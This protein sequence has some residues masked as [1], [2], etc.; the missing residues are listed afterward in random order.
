M[1]LLLGLL[2]LLSAMAMASDNYV[3]KDGTTFLQGTDGKLYPVMLGVTT[4]GNSMPSQPLTIKNG[5]T[6]LNG[7]PVIMLSTSDGSGGFGP[8]TGSQPSSSTNFYVDMGGHD[9]TTCGAVMV[10]CLT[11]KYAQ[12]RF[13]DEKITTGLGPQ[14]NKQYTIVIGPGT[15]LEDPSW[16]PKQYVNYIGYSKDLTTIQHSDF[17]IID[18]QYGDNYG[19][20]QVFKDLA[21]YGLHLTRIAGFTDPTNMPTETNFFFQNCNLGG[22]GVYRGSG[23][24][25]GF[26]LFVLESI[27]FDHTVSGNR[28]IHGIQY[29]ANYDQAHN[30]IIDSDGIDQAKPLGGGYTDSA[31]QSQAHRYD[32]RNYSGLSAVA[33]SILQVFLRAPV[34]GSDPFDTQTFGPHP[35][36]AGDA[37]SQPA[38]FL[39]LLGGSTV[40]QVSFATNKAAI[41]N[42]SRFSV[43]SGASFACSN[44]E[45]IFVNQSSPQASALTLCDGTTN[46]HFE[47]YDYTGDAA[48]NNITL[49]TSRFDRFKGGGTTFVMNQ[50]NQ[51]T[52]LEWTPIGATPGSPATFHIQTVADSSGSLAGANFLIYGVPSKDGST[53]G[54][55]IAYQL[56]YKVSGTGSAPTPITG[57]PQFEVDIATNDTAAAVAT[58]T[59]PVL[60]FVQT[61]REPGELLNCSSFASDT[62][63]CTDFVGGVS[64]APADGTP[65]TGFT[66]TQT[67]PGVDPINGTFFVH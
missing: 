9:T 17:S 67:V 46:Q 26:P 47:V 38:Q 41:G 37:S 64:T 11:I 61:T 44:E 25:Q 34:D 57:V 5:T 8:N 58:A 65:A 35:S 59:L 27:T 1:K 55:P 15:Y 30:V 31:N 4:D 24:D 33:S 66:L 60:Q 23:Y 54:T 45:K 52:Q 2:L 36:F 48:T 16:A 49:H 39:N 43:M 53:P 62:I 13:S 20:F 22:Q 19:F 18:F 21:I 32:L 56:W 28:E 40:V 29:H 50:N 6:F 42:Q 51:V 63:E 3:T 12:N 14:F 7:S 10:P